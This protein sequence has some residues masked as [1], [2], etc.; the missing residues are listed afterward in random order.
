MVR[1]CQSTALFFSGSTRLLV[2]M[3]AVVRSGEGR[4]I[5]LHGRQGMGVDVEGDLNPLMAQAFLHQLD[6]HA[7]LQQQGRTGMP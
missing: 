4:S 6:G 1:G 7:S 3:L 2:G 5:L